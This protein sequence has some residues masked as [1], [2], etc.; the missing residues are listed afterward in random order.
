MTSREIDT[1]LLI[2]VPS[3]WETTNRRYAFRALAETLPRNVA[4]ICVDRPLDFLVTP[5]KRPRRFLSDIWRLGDVAVG[6]RLRV[7][8]PR[9]LLHE[10]PAARIPGITAINR[11]LLRRQLQR[12][13]RHRFPGTRR[14]IQ[15]IHHPVQRWVYDVFPAAGRV[16]HCYDEYT[17]SDDGCFHPGRWEREARVIKE[18]AITFITSDSLRRRR[19]KIARRLALI[20]NGIPEFFFDRRPLGTDPIDRIP[21]PRIGYLG[22][23][24][25]LLDYDLLREICIRRPEW[26]MVF[27]GPI[28]RESLLQNLRGLPNAH[29]VGT[30]PHE[31]LPVI[32]QRFDVGLMPFLINDFTRPLV[33]LKLYE[34]LAAGV[35]VVSTDLPNLDS[36]RSL[37][38]LVP[39]EVD[40]FEAAIVRELEGDR[41]A[42][43]SRLREAARAFTWSQINKEYVI[44]VLREEFGF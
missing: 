21:R 8:R 20:P 27:V 26:Q 12:V 4:V 43:A 44:P 7:V 11:T 22:H 2:Y 23:V 38:Q 6:E 13:I 14:V 15:W 37:I 10:I 3:I 42:I 18:A 34:Y 35:P 28:Q 17:C 24:F 19:E 5:I 1:V 25:A 16:Y 9:L 39:G 41:A 29:F 32:L 31:D 36:F 30:R 40:A 33:P